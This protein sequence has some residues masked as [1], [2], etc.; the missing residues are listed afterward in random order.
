MNNNKIYLAHGLDKTEIGKYDFVY[1]NDYFSIAMYFNSNNDK[2]LEFSHTH[3]EYEFIFPLGTIPILVYDKALYVGEVGYCYPVNPFV[4]HG[5]GMNLDSKVI[6]IAFDKDYF[7]KIKEKLGKK[8]KYF[9]TRF[10][11]EKDLLLIIQQ[12][13][14][15]RNQNLIEKIATY[16]INDGLKED[17]DRR[18]KP[19][20]YFPYIRDSIIYIFENY[21]NP[22]LT[23]DDIARTTPY[24][25]AYYT[26]AFRKFMDDTPIN[27]LNRVRISKARELIDGTNDSLLEISKQVGYNRS[28]KFC[29]A[30][31]RITGVKPNDYKRK[32]RKQNID[33]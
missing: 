30:F 20:S 12:F 27:Y 2:L 24:S 8:D 26:K 14:L 6:S 16:L 28:S 18:K 29:E 9:Y 32:M 22:N 15:T 10:L 4:N 19:Y 17:I 5:I 3:S 7:D 25:R 11:I 23:V 33:D 13:Y 1:S 31:K 21:D